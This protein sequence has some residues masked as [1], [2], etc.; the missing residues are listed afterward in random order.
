[1]EWLFILG[2]AGWGWWQ[3]RRIETLETRLREMDQRFIAAARA[4]A[5]NEP[6]KPLPEA[7]SPPRM[8]PDTPPAAAPPPPP[9]TLVPPPPAPAPELE[10][11]VLDTPVAPD[12]LVLDTPLPPEIKTD[13]QAA[14]YRPPPQPKAPG[15]RRFEKWIA[16]NG[17]AWIG[18]AALAFGVISLVG[19]AARQG[20]FTPPVRLTAA[21]LGGLVLLALS[22]IVRR[23]GKKAPSAANPLVASLLAAAG[24]VSFYA[25][26]WAAHGIYNYV[27]WG[28]AAALLAACAALLLALSRLHGQPLGVLAVG[29]AMLAPALTQLVFWP[30][31]PLSLF[32]TAMAAAGLAVAWLRR[33]SWVALATIT[34][35]YF[36]FAQSLQANEIVRALA[37]L[38][39]ASFGGVALA[40]RPPLESEPDSRLSWKLA[41]AIGPTIAV[42]I[43]SVLVLWAWLAAAPRI[44]GNIAG[45]AMIAAFHVA[46]AAA[47]VRARVASPIALA[48]AVATLVLGFVIFLQTRFQAPLGDRFYPSILFAAVVIAAA[49]LEARP[50]RTQRVLVAAFGAL[51][52]AMLVLLAAF[53]A[54]QWYGPLAWAPLFTGALGLLG[55]AWLAARESAAPESDRV[56]DLWAGAG[57]ALALAG[58]ESACPA[59]GRA[60]AYGGASLAFAALFMWRGWRVARYAALAGAAFALAQALSANLT[61]NA[62]AGTLPL[63]QALL[64]LAGAA[65]T[66]F[67][68]NLLVA[69][70]QPMSAASESLSSAAILLVIIAAFLIVRFAVSGGAGAAF[71][72]FAEDALRALALVAAGHIVLP[73]RGVQGGAILQWRGHA[74]MGAGLAY[75]LFNAGLMHNPWWGVTPATIAGPYIVD[76]MALAY[77]A[78]GALALFAANRLYDRQHVFA[79]IAA[80]AGGLF[81]LIWLVLV[82]RRFFHPHDMSPA[83]V[84][85]FEGACYALIFL[86]SA[87]AIVSIA[88]MRAARAVGKDRPFT[89]D[90]MVITRASAWT[91]IIA[92]SFI[93]L[94]ARHPWWGAQSSDTTDALST[95]LATLAQGAAMAIALFLGRALS[96]KVG[97][98]STR[99]AAAAAAAVYAWS[100]G[101][102]AIRWLHMQ[103]A[104]DDS[105]R[106]AG[107]EGFGHALW[108]LIFV[109]AASEITQRAPGRDT[110][111]SYLYDLQAIWAAAVWPALAFAGLGLWAIFCPWWGA[112]PAQISSPIAATLALVGI[113]L[114]AGLGIYATRMPKLR[115]ADWFARAAT[116]AC[117][118]H[119]FVALTLTVR[120]LYRGDAMASLTPAE[121]FEMWTYSTTWAVFGAGVLGAGVWRGDQVLRW[122][123]IAILIGAS[124]KV[125]FVDTARVSEVIRAGSLLGLGAILLFVAWATRRIGERRPED[126]IKIRSNGRREKPNG[127]RQRSR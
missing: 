73:R 126:L 53:T 88:R 114:A 95:G 84:G 108:P 59:L 23:A 101:H 81:T 93:L 22:E 103:G 96:R 68:A 52:A 65:V 71:D 17:F 104:M 36:W 74:L 33:W 10:P 118:A 28:A 3:S 45:P 39:L 76:M 35:L 86:L 83:S 24:A 18:G 115:A 31:W 85:L 14:A 9:L 15:D 122:C 97:P 50:H 66:L 32:V 19:V 20:W 109:V 79:R 60:A 58:V 105:T 113:L 12:E 112:A 123:A 90:L 124:A 25:T 121:G 70:R 99:F 34:A 47:A 26:V 80:A 61:G 29:A 7:P 57:A 110:V 62:L 69:R 91:G 77:A 8:A 117:V 27:G 30:Y 13:A 6:L 43:S 40:T 5:W 55:C 48:V 127:R 120:F 21:M 46:L 56:V 64:V 67:A 89:Y 100:F 51:G 119:L 49:S 1:M 102:C 87:L 4:G 107:L 92:A 78:P 11:L 75:G 111:R 98:D 38:S 125:F 54:P 72:N 37:F 63:W 94:L 41:Q 16:Q 44:D 82:V 42:C 106:M 2:L 116:I